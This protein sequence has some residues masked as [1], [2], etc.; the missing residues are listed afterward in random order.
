MMSSFFSGL[1][2]D[3]LG[4]WGYFWRLTLVVTLFLVLSA[5]LG[6]S[7]GISNWTFIFFPMAVVLGF[8]AFNI[9]A[10]RLRDLSLPGWLMVG[11]LVALIAAVGFVIS[12]PAEIYLAIAIL[13]LL[14]I[15]PGRSIKM[16]A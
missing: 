9:L 12:G 1:R 5:D 10:K 3:R 2:S 16:A 15:L 6:L 4:P 11:C 8:A 13:L 14:A 7:G